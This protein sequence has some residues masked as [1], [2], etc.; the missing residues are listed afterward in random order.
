MLNDHGVRR[1][2]VAV[3]QLVVEDIHH[4]DAALADAARRFLTRPS[5]DLDR[6]VTLAGLR[7]EAVRQRVRRLTRAA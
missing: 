2:A 4:Q 5:D 6:W 1:L 3:L 7:T